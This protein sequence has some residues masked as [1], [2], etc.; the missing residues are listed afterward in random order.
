LKSHDSLLP[1][2]PCILRAGRTFAGEL[3]EAAKDSRPRIAGRAH[4][5]V[6]LLL[7]L[8]EQ[9]SKAENEEVHQACLDVWDQLLKKRVVQAVELTQELDRPS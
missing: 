1:F 9:S 6:P 8:Y 5:L 2:A 7:R 3:A 4:T